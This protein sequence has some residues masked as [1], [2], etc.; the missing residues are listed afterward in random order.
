M[1]D[2]HADVDA[3]KDTTPSFGGRAR[4]AWTIA[5]VELRRIFFTKRGIGV[6]VLA[7]LP[8]LAFLG[9]GIDAKLQ[10]DRLTRRGLVDAARMNS[11]QQ[12]DTL[13]T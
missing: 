8:A 2:R 5:K 9:H 13:R 6:Y 3:E 11:I 7:V 10:I 1:P 4:Q 12:G